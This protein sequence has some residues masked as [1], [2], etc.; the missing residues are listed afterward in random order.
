MVRRRRI[1]GHLKTEIVIHR[2]MIMAQEEV[3]LIGEKQCN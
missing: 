2:H 3:V 1:K